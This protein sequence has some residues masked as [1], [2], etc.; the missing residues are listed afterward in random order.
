MSISEEIGRLGELHQ[1]GVLSDDEF[2][3]AKARVI[4]EATRVPPPAGVAA[5]N[6]LRRSRADRW[7]GGVCGG[8]AEATGLAAWIWRLTFTLLALCGGTGVLM[9][10]LLWIFVP[11]GHAPLDSG[12]G[13]FSA[14]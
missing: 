3:R 14:S 6:G 7:L 12:R 5:V 2:A 9:Y 8:L 11:A 13:Q 10:V 4:D 1:H